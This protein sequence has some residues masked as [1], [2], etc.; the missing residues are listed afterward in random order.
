MEKLYTTTEAANYLKISELTVRRYIKA[1][2]IKSHILGR[3]HRI[4]KSELTK[5]VNELATRHPRMK[6]KSKE[7]KK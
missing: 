6:D 1:G 5:F 2:K 3:R 7:I 4:P